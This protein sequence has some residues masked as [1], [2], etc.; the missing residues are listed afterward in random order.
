MEGDMKTVLLVS[1]RISYFKILLV[2]D[3]TEQNA[4]GYQHQNNKAK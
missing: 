2:K 1:F 4:E 3:I